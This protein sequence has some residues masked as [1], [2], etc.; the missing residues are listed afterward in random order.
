ML[1]LYL[2]LTLISEFVT[3][4]VEGTEEEIERHKKEIDEC[5]KFV[6]VFRKMLYGEKSQE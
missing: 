5:T 2:R 6:K 1:D 3:G 4:L